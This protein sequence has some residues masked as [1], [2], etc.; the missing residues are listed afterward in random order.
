[1]KKFTPVIKVIPH[2]R[3]ATKQAI[4]LSKKTFGKTEKVNNFLTELANIFLF[5]AHTTKEAFSRD[6]E[7]REFLR[8][9]FQIGYK[10]LPL[11]SVTGIIMGLV[12]NYSIAARTCS[13]RGGFYASGNGSS[14]SHKGNGAGYYRIDMRRKN[15]FR[16]GCRVRFNESNRAD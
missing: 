2:L 14:I 6:F 4:K 12:F 11:I 8:Q 5:I 7:F 1:M 9:C 16:H 13:F 15:R 3:G 10:T